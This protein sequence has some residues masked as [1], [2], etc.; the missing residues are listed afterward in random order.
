MKCITIDVVLIQEMPSMNS[1]NPRIKLFHTMCVILFSEQF[2]QRLFKMSI[3]KSE[4]KFV[5][6]VTVGGSVK[7]LPAEQISSETTRVDICRDRHDLRSCKI[8][9]SCVKFSG[10]QCFFL[11]NLRRCPKF[12]HARCDFTFESFNFYTFSVIK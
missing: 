12:T 10:K 2:L 8:C 6:A 3:R 9:A 11:H 7:F 4:V 1:Q 5:S